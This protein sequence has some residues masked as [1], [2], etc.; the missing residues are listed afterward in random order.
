MEKALQIGAVASQTGLTVDAIRFYE[1]A[2]LLPAV[3]RSTGGF[4]LFREQDV[5]ELRFI[6]K[7]QELGFSLE[8]IREL[9]SLRKGSPTPCAS[10]EQL[11]NKKLLAVR[12]KLRG[13]Q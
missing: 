2:R 11:L 13:L 7:A 9:I 5:E 12:A 6:R 3:P 8:E 4:R 1:R 10:V